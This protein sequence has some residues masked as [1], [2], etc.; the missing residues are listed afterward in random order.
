MSLARHLRKSSTPQER[1]LWRYLRNR[2]FEGWKFRRQ[3]PIERYILDFYCPKAR[4]AIEL[5]GGG[6]NFSSKESLDQ[7]RTKFLESKGI[8][9]LR[10]W[11]PQITKELDSVL[12]TIWLTLEQRGNPSP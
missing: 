9:V 6:H 12:E 4:L 10:F 5:D 7:E 8:A 3:H 1:L 2:Q 11:N